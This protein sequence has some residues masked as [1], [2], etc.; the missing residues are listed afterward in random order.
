MDITSLVFLHGFA[1][2]FCCISENNREELRLL[3]SDQVTYMWIEK[4]FLLSW[5]VDLQVIIVLDRPTDE[6]SLIQIMYICAYTE[7]KRLAYAKTIHLVH[8]CISYIHPMDR[9]HLHPLTTKLD[10][11]KCQRV[12]LPY[13]VIGNLSI[14]IAKFS[15]LISA[16]RNPSRI[17]DLFASP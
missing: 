14:C 9:R 1:I 12:H 5:F 17:T 11:A 7:C 4:Y 13:S 15:A 8:L 16:F 3:H 10:K 6:I 2:S